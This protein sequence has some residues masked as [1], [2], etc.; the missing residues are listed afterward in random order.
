MWITASADMA[1]ERLAKRYATTKREIL[2]RL[3]IDADS[4]I[5]RRL[6]SNSPEWEAYFNVTR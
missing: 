4:K 3:I 6:P 1:L 2:E 5:Q